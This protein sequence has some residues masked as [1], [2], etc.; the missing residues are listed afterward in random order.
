MVIEVIGYSS[1][2]LFVSEENMGKKQQL[3]MVSTNI[4]KEAKQGI[5]EN[6]MRAP[7]LLFRGGSLERETSLLRRLILQCLDRR[8]NG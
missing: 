8:E 2:V 6:S 5:R 7:A 3:W 1:H 4:F